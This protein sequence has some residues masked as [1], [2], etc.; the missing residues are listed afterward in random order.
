MTPYRA[1]IIGT[2]G[3]AHSHMAAYRAL[4]MLEVVAGAD[5]V[6]ANCE[7]FC[8]KW[9][10]PRR[11][12]DWRELLAAERPQI[13]SVCTWEDSHAKIVVAAAESG[14]Q[15]ILC[16]KPMAMDL[17]EADRM[18][19]ACEKSGTVLAI[20]HMRRYNPHY[21]EAQRLLGAGAIGPVE[22]MWAYMGGWDVFLW[23][24][25]YADML[26]YLNGDG[27]LRWVMGQIDWATRGMGYPYS[28]RFRERRGPDWV[29][30]D[31]ALGLMEFDNGVRVV[32]ESGL[33]S[34]GLWQSAGGRHSGFCEIRIY[35]SE[36]E[37]R[38]GD[39]HLAHRLRGAAEWT[40][41]SHWS[42]ETREQFTNAMFIAEMKELVECVETGREHPLN[43]RRGRKALEMLMAIYESARRRALVTLPLAVP[44]NPLLTMAKAGDLG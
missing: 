7:S 16:E 32:W 8:A 1:A 25:H 5:I 18:L 23:G 42:Q 6:P 19:A 10:V 15:G 33:H 29:A 11:Y 39:T 43:G 17:A 35:G 4:P 37:I 41:T 21:A 12:A 2:G 14:V 26:H 38:V 40:R 34:P 30:E 20:G 24:I 27:S 22:R 3:I 31:D 36:G 44:D 28:Q 13:L 9:A